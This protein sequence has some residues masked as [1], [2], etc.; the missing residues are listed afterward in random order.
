MGSRYGGLRICLIHASG[1]DP[2][3]T[4]RE[5]RLDGKTVPVARMVACKLLFHH[6]SGFQLGLRVSLVLSTIRFFLHSS[7]CCDGFDNG[8][9]RRRRT[10]CSSVDWR[11]L[12]NSPASLRIRASRRGWQCIEV[13]STS[14]SAVGSA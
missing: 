8:V 7:Y 12:A 1:D 11:K 9:L 13:G 10:S 3:T 5:R 14:V 2:Y 6:L 4:C